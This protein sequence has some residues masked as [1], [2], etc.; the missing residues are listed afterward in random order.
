MTQAELAG[1]MANAP[2]VRPAK[3]QLIHDFTLTIPVRALRTTM[4]TPPLQFT[5][6]TGSA[7]CLLCTERQRDRRCPTRRRL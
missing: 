2:H 3:G 6:P 1:G 4:I 5:L 7:R